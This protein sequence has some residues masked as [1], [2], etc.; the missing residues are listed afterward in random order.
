MHACIFSERDGGTRGALR[1]TF[2]FL[3]LFPGPPER[4][5]PLSNS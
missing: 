5:H 1:Y 3:V 4:N 2:R